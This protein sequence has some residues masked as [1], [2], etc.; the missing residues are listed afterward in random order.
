M[1]YKIITKKRIIVTGIYVITVVTML[2][3]GLLAGL[4]DFWTTHLLSFYFGL[5][6]PVVWELSE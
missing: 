4:L 3:F 2:A 5:F 1:N 6:A